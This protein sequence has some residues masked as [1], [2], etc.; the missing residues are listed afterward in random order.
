V[1]GRACGLA[2]A[3]ETNLNAG[4][5][6]PGGQRLDIAIREQDNFRGALAWAVR[7]GSIGL[8]LEIATALEQFKVVNDPSEGIR[9]FERL[10]GRA[11][12]EDVPQSLRA[13]ALRSYG[14][15]L[16]IAGNHAV[17]EDTWTQSLALFED[18]ADEHGRAV[19]LHRLGI[20]AMRRGELGRAR[21]LV[22]ASD[23]IHRSTG[24]I[25]GRAQ[26][27]GTLGA[28]TRDEGDE[29]NALD[30]V[31][32]SAALANQA[33]VPWWESGALAELACLSLN[34][35]LLE[36]GEARAR[37]SL[38]LANRHRDRP[39]RIFGVGILARVAAERGQLER[40]GRLWGAIEDE[41]AGA[42]LGGWRRH[43]QRC[44][45]RIRGLSG[46]D[47]DG[48]RAEGRASTLDEAVSLALSTPDV[49]PS[50][51]P[52]GG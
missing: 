14:S 40:A 28:I 39:G 31:R 20:S 38:E 10:F 32:R 7:G 19:L 8:G 34:V 35:G 2:V 6:R 3:E 33:G 29:R 41:D 25:W 26:T 17:A 51:D 42:P 47:F 9:W 13:H 50:R 23:A 30:L 27:A 49:E 44:E 37:E 11:E 15:S 4:A 36:E 21:E 52:A 16:D 24:D 48:G 5:L 12:A 22:E 45:G 18:L 46:P 43:R 1:P